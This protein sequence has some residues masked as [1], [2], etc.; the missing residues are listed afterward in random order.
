MTFS[1]QDALDFLP[2]L[3]GGIGIALVAVGAVA[4]L[5][6]C[7]GLL[8]A[9]ARLSHSLFLQLASRAWIELIEGRPRCCRSTTSTSCCPRWASL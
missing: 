8:L 2:S 7:Q 3:A 4:V 9:L 6:L 5:A 1:I